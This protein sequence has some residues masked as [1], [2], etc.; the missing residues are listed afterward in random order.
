[1]HYLLYR[2][3]AHR[4]HE[5]VP[6]VDLTYKSEMDT[7]LM[8]LELD[9]F[10]TALVQD[11]DVDPEVILRHSVFGLARTGLINDSWTYGNRDDIGL[12]SCSFERVLEVT[13]T[14]RGM[15]LYGWAL[16][17]SD[18]LP[19]TFASRAFSIAVEEDGIP[20]LEPVELPFI[21]DTE[22]EQEEESKVS[23]S[24]QMHPSRRQL[25]GDGQGHETF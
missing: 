8:R 14:G 15:E 23:R 19:R 12:Q 18:L 3:W 22:E 11:T 20:R 4:L 10:E 2:E 13:P 5:A 25:D 7:A 17:M 24:R 1:M 6:N 9:G 16:G 21:D